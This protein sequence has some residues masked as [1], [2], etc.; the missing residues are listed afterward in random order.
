MRRKATQ[1]IE[2]LIF[3]L[4][5]G[6]HEMK[7]KLK[8]FQLRMVLAVL[9]AVAIIFGLAPLDATAQE[10]KAAAAPGHKDLGAVGA[11]L[12]NPL[13]DL[14][15]LSFNLQAPQFFD[16]DV[17]AGDPQVGGNLIFQPVL[18]IPLFGSGDDEWRM[19][20]RPVIPIIFST[21]IPKGIDKFDDTGGIGDIQLPLLLA[22]PAKHAGKWILGAGPVGLFPSATDDDLGSDQWALGPAVV[23]GYRAKS[24]T[25]VLFP[26]YFWKIGSNGQNDNTPDISQ[27]TLLYSLTVKLPNAWQVGFNPTISYNDRAASGDKWNVPV[28]LFV[29]RTVKMGKTPVNIKAGLEYSVV[30]PDSFGQRAQ[31]RFQITPVVPSLIKDP[32]FGK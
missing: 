2:S 18:P 4:E 19:I 1:L 32:I 20:T 6:V 26:N 7:V 21:P 14:W 24:W 22:V 9:S 13:S 8:N 17:N 23:I 10:E 25:A 29:G 12:A 15:S 16:G 11:K 3:Y 30:S 5:K 31:F 28:G 27:G